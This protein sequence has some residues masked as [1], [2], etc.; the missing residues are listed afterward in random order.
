MLLVEPQSFLRGQAAL[1]RLCV[2]AVHL[3]QHLQHGRG[4]AGGEE[5][6]AEQ[7]LPSSLKEGE[8]Q[9]V[10]EVEAIRK[11]TRPPK[12]LT[13]ATLLTAME[14]AGKTDPRQQTRGR[15]Q[16]QLGGSSVNSLV[17]TRESNQLSIVRPILHFS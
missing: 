17:E 15:S 16:I 13:E 4:K 7:A 9:E 14:T 3:A 5:Q 12:R 6:Q 2:I 1:T 10:V 11:K 8:S